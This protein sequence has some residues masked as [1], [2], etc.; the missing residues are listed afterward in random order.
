MMLILILIYF[1]TEIGLISGGSS[2]VHIYTQT[3]HTTTQLTE[4]KNKNLSLVDEIITKYTP[5]VYIR[6]YSNNFLPVL[7]KTNYFGQ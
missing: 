4:K 1:L 5:F 2:M 6:I 3:I 7:N